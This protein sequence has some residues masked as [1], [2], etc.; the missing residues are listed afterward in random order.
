MTE[1]EF[2]TALNSALVAGFAVRNVEAVGVQSAYQPRRQGAPSA[3]NILLFKINLRP[4]GYPK[5]TSGWVA[6][7]PPTDPPTGQMV[8]TE[9]QIYEMTVQF[10]GSV[11]Q[12]PVDPTKPAGNLLP[13]T[14]GDIC[15]LAGRALQS[16]AGVAQLK[17]AGIGV[18]KLLQ[19]PQSY[20]SDDSDAFEQS[21]HFDL[22]FTFI[23]TETT[24]GP[25][26]SKLGFKV[27]PV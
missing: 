15:K 12:P 23:D 25:I 16:W 2:F 5:S 9:V 19:M 8:R 24:L 20:F 3:M 7:N 27:V 11:K 26:I 6:A 10:T 18:E 14:A 13:Y 1:T 21:P 17:A 4:F 22:V